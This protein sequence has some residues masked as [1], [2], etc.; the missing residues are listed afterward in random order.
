MGQGD[1]L[2]V[3]T[4]LPARGLSLTRRWIS[5][6]CFKG[7][8]SEL[9]WNSCGFTKEVTHRFTKGPLRGRGTN[10]RSPRTFLLRN[11]RWLGYGFPKIV[12]K[13]HDEPL[14]IGK[15]KWFHQ[16]CGPSFYWGSPT[17]Q[18]GLTDSPTYFSPRGLLLTRRWISYTCLKGS[19]WAIELRWLTLS[20]FTINVSM[21]NVSCNIAEDPLKRRGTKQWSP[22]TFLLVDYRWLGDRFPTIVLKGYDEPLNLIGF[23]QM[24]PKRW[25]IVFLKVPYEAGG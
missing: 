21:H 4:Y 9:R 11:F 7:W 14:N 23:S 25:P 20:Q 13:G 6:N 12:L 16:K 2:M 10:Q 17:G 1:E 22:H 19:W 3:P 15:F 18:G 5:H 8:A 24:W